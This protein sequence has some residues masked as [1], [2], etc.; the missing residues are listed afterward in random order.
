MAVE[1]E[2]VEKARQIVYDHCSPSVDPV[3]KKVTL[4]VL[5]MDRFEKV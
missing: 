4:F 1:A 3:L 5:K 2:K